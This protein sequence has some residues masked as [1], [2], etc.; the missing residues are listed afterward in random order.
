MRFGLVLA[1]GMGLAPLH[2][3]AEAYPGLQI[4]AEH[5]GV[6]YM[7]EITAE[8]KAGPFDARV[9]RIDGGS[10]SYE[11]KIGRDLVKQACAGESYSFRN[12]QATLIEGQL[13][14]KGVCT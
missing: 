13:M 1:I 8:D 10:M 5:R 11:R 6:K 12:V 4:P 9:W 3:G 7:V 14:F 2:A